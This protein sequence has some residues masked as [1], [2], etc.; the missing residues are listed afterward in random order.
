MRKTTSGKHGCEIHQTC[1]FNGK[2]FKSSASG[3]FHILS[4]NFRLRPTLS[5]ASSWYSVVLASQSMSM[6]DLQSF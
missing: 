3:E 2:V 1:N 4:S 6:D 5:E